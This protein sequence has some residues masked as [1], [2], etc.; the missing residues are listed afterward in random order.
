MY[1]RA[2]SAAYVA[3]LVIIQPYPALANDCDV[4]LFKS[5]YQGNS[6]IKDDFRLAQ[7]VSQ[8]TWDNASHNAGAN[9]VIYGIPVGASY[10]DYHSHAQRISSS[11]NQSL[12]YE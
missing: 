7:Y 9:A 4:N 8:E 6:S 11:L 5:A 1:L 2:L 10:S 3:A 12:N